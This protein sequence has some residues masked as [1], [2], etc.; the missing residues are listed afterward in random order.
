MLPL[1][2]YNLS[3]NIIDMR[4]QFGCR[5]M[6]SLHRPWCLHSASLRVVCRDGP[7]LH[8]LQ[9]K[10]HTQ[11]ARRT[12]SSARARAKSDSPVAVRKCAAGAC[13]PNG[14]RTDRRQNHGVV[15]ASKT[16]QQQGIVCLHFFRL[17]DSHPAVEMIYPGP[18]NDCISHLRVV[19]GG[20]FAMPS[21]SR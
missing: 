13:T 3:K 20:Y 6:L 10:G 5:C 15:P 7:F 12:C 8:Q 19:V 4:A 1:H 17:R 14:R 9:E 18:R 2:R 21:K 16:S 11:D